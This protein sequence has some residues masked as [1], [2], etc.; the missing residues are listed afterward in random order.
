MPCRFSS[1]RSVSSRRPVAIPKFAQRLL[2]R[3]ICD[4]QPYPFGVAEQ[5]LIQVG[6]E[7]TVAVDQPA[8]QGR[9]VR[10]RL[11]AFGERGD[12]FAIGLGVGLPGIAV[13]HRG[14][15]VANK[16]RSEVMVAQ[17]SDQRVGH[18]PAIQWV[19]QETVAAVA[20]D[21]HRTAVLGG[22]QRQSARGG[23][24]Q[25]QP[26]GLGQGRVD[27]DAAGPSDKAIDLGHLL[28]AMML[29]RRDLAVE[30]VG[31]DGEQDVGQ[32]GARALVEVA[33]VV[34][35][36]GDDQQIGE[37]LKLGRFAVGFE[38]SD[39][40]LAVIGAGQRQDQRLVGVVQEALDIRGETNRRILFGGRMKLDQVGPGRDD[41][42]ALRLVIVVEGVLLFDL[43]VGAGDDQIR[44]SEDRFLGIDAT[45][46]VV[47]SVDL[48]AFE[49]G[50]EET[51]AFVATQ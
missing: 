51:L 43:V 26:E 22:N 33:D 19:D 21:V 29:R 31:V 41:D 4:E 15:T 5:A 28:G 6:K 36:A 7:C 50:G 11:G 34:P 25:G 18:G 30:V 16:L 46:H 45:Y 1:T 48:L 37:R 9:G 13:A 23:F 49:S 20:D 3:I 32:N 10:D 47:A 14:Q 35:V 39:D 17:D 40:V 2:V 27:E 42:H 38:Q 44:R 12:P 8:A 24:Q